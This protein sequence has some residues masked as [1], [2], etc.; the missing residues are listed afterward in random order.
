M[1]VRWKATALAVTALLTVV[2]CTSS[3]DEPKADPTPTA[4]DEVVDESLDENAGCELLDAD[5]RAALLGSNLNAVA[6]ADAREGAV[7]CRWASDKGL[8]QVTDLAAEAWAKTLPEIVA[9]MEQSAEVQDADGKAQLAKAKK[10]LS[11]ADSFTGK[12]ACEAFTTLAEIGGDKPGTTTTLSYLPIS[13][14]AVGISA[15]TCSSGRLTSLVFSTPKL[16]ESKAYERKVAAALKAA[17]ARAVA[18]Q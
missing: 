13:E 17:H 9:Q 6:A 8:I 5:D 12:Q 11:G 15:Q 7:Q 14:E 1:S 3:D 10:L 16:K 18:R 2:G 4:T